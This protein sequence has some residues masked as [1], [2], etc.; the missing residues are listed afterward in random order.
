MKTKTLGMMALSLLTLA[1][2]N[3]TNKENAKTSLVPA[4]KFDLTHWKITIPTDSNN[5]GKVDGISAKE[6]QTYQHPEFF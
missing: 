3:A 5:D 1:G 2:C 6:I 4:D